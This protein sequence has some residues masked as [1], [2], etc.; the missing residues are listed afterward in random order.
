VRAIRT[1]RSIKE[2]D[3]RQKER[4]IAK[5]FADVWPAVMARL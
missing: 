5:K 3:H 2:F 1:F 4:Y